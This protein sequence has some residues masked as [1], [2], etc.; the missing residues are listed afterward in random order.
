MNRIIGFVIILM[1]CFSCKQSRRAEVS[2][3]S[4]VHDFGTISSDSICRDSII[5]TN[6]GNA[7]LEIGEVETGCGCTHASV[8][9]S[10]LNPKESC[11]LH[12]SFNPKGKG[13][14]PKKELIIINAN[15]D[16]LFYILQIKAII[17]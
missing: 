11:A 1:M 6:V 13:V 17:Q 9:K 4:Y 3:S 10:E 16:S 7:I 15:T 8:D 12:F 5:L 2:L 14:G